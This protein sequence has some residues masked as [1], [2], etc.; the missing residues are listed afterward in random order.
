MAALRLATGLAMPEP[1]PTTLPRT[2]TAKV[3]I[4]SRRQLKD[5]VKLADRCT[6]Q[7]V[8]PDGFFLVGRSRS[9]R[10]GSNSYCRLLANSCS[11][12]ERDHHLDAVRSQTRR[13]M[14]RP[15]RTSLGHGDDFAMSVLLRVVCLT[16]RSEDWP[17]WQFY[18]GWPFR[19]L[20]PPGIGMDRR[21]LHPDIPTMKASPRT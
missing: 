16:M 10:M 14:E 11:N 5:S 20:E 4:V 8:W 17:H 19:Y 13:I 7:C 2:G 18:I 15:L 3:S 9:A 1:V 21:P 6:C 12:R